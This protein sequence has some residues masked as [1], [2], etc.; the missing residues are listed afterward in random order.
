M[1]EN[2]RNMGGVE[3]T[4][5]L[6]TFVNIHA[7]DHNTG[8]PILDYG[9]I[10]ADSPKND[11]CMSSLI[12]EEHSCITEEA[13]DIDG[14]GK[15][16]YSYLQGECHNKQACSIEFYSIFTL[17]IKPSTSCQKDDIIFFI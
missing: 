8:K 1:A 6:N 9:V 13:K 17:D 12:P 10:G 11:Y 7:K 16:F 2:S 5:P 4:C 15:L 14:D 3:I